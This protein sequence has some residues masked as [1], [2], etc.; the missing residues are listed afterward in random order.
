MLRFELLD[1]IRHQGP[2]SRAEIAR[3]IGISKP[4]VSS[5]VE[6]LLEAELVAEAGLADSAG[7]RRGVLLDFKARAGYVIGMDVGGSVARAALADLRGDELHTLREA[8]AHGNSSGLI[9]QLVR[10]KEALILRGNIEAHKVL[11]VAIGTPGVVDPAS[12]H[13]HY[14]PNLPELESLNFLAELEQALQ[15]P[16]TLDNDVNLAAVGEKWQGAGQQLES[17]IFVGIGTGLGFGLVLNGELY[18]GSKG[19][20]GEF[21]YTSFPTKQ[22]STLEELL[23][24]SGLA[25]QHA[26]AGGSGRSADAFDEAAAGL[27]PG[28]TIIQIFLERLAWLLSALTTLFDPERLILGGGIGMRCKPHLELLHEAVTA[29]TPIIPKIVLSQLGDDAGLKGA[30]AMALQ[31]SELHLT[32]LVK[33]MGV[34][35]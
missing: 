30:I 16:V 26:Q 8:T 14:A 13:V 29:Q 24:G 20:A 25:K 10:L 23:S 21:G 5:I 2:I 17:F 12:H 28:A 33:E 35:T 31:D 11:S 15:L 7:G 3:Q 27:E 34:K 1:L 4:T 9:A 6:G 19:R 18:R 22:D 32:E